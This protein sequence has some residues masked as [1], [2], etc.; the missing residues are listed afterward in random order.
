[1]RFTAATVLALVLVL[2]A[3]ALVDAAPLLT[4]QRRGI[5]SK[6]KSVAGHVASAGRTAAGASRM[7]AGRAV[8]FVKGGVSKGEGRLFLVLFSGLSVQY[9]GTRLKSFLR[10]TV[11]GAV[12]PN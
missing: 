6:G 1:M 9:N 5:I 4:H 7:A 10:C 2:L 3:V 11:P 8:D 12:P